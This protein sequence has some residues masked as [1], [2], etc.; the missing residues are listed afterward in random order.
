MG[1]VV[2]F[3]TNRRRIALLPPQTCH[4][5]SD[6]SLRDHVRIGE[7]PLREPFSSHVRVSIVRGSVSHRR[8]KLDAS[9]MLLANAIIICRV[10]HIRPCRCTA[11]S[12]TKATAVSSLLCVRSRASSQLGGADSRRRVDLRYSPDDN[13]DGWPRSSN[14]DAHNVYRSLALFFS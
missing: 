4:K 5:S 13:P 6:G 12:S 8:G 3:E 11:V 10:H 1:L 7:L 14:T 2:A 9:S